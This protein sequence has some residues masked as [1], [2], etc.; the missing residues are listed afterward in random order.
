MKT[1]ASK[2]LAAL[3]ASAAHHSLENEIMR[4]RAQWL[5]TRIDELF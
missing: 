2:T 5:S 4:A 3:A 1:T